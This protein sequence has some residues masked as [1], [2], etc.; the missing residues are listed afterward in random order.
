MPTIEATF[1]NPKVQR[2][3]THDASWFLSGADEA[4]AA[5]IDRLT[6]TFDGVT[7]CRDHGDALV[8]CIQTADHP[9]VRLW[10]ALFSIQET[11][12]SV[13]ADRSVVVSDHFKN[14]IAALPVGERTITDEIIAGHF[15]T[16]KVYGAGS[17][18]SPISRLTH[19]TEVDIDATTGTW[20]SRLFDR[21][22]GDTEKRTE[23]EYLAVID[24][25]LIQSIGAVGDPA[26][27]ALLFS[28]GVDSTLLLALDPDLMQ[29]LTFVPDSPEFSDETRYARAAAHLVGRDLIEVPVAERDFV[30]NLET[31][32][33]IVG[34]PPFDDSS[35][36]FDRLIASRPFSTFIS[37]HGADSAFGMSLKL[38]KFSNWFRFPGIRL[39]LQAVA[40][41]APGHLGYRMRQV[42]S[43][44]D[45]FSK[46]PFDPD[47]FAGN[48]RSHGDTSLFEST[49]GPELPH[50]VKED[51][52]AYVTDRV[53]GAGGRSSTFLSHIELAHWMVV[54]GN[55]LC[56]E[57]MTTQPRGARPTCPYTD[58]AVLVE[59]ARIPV[60]DRYISGYRAK[61]ILKDLLTRKVPAYPVDQRKKATALPWERFYLDG[62]LTDIWDRY[63]IPDIFPA[64]AQD[65]IRA[66]P[67][68]TT[69]NAITWAM[70]DERIRRNPNL[71]PHP[72]V[73]S[74]SASFT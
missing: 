33:D 26:D 27:T 5:S 14:A 23:A 70:W 37:G 54:F 67:S 65:G 39:G 38:A 62:P 44:A 68:A 15:I 31:V 1:T 22:S 25:R 13:R 46:D 66:E 42:S 59:L 50:K 4:D 40:P 2:V 64:A 57:R 47:G 49:I 9:R 8:V 17:Y 52:L 43:R 45:A 12:F 71:R 55:A 3:D 20:S 56:E 73:A 51:E 11:W 34:F 48:A 61:W 35:P 24:E 21:V 19:A 6:S 16:R 30:E 63:D 58:A 41:R 29:P 28:G 7:F 60:E 69:W 74:L 72:A 18:V 10:K 53:E 36:Y 32:V